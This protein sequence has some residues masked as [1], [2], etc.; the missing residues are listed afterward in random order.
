MLLGRLPS[1]SEKRLSTF[2]G[3]Q[4]FLAREACLVVFTVETTEPQ[5]SQVIPSCGLFNVVM[6][7]PM[8]DAQ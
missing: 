4:H 2:L 6:Q 8:N 3:T 1:F 7:A 5:R